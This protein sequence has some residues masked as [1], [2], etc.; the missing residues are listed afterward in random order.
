M[1]QQE[2]E[3]VRET[4]RVRRTNQRHSQNRKTA[5]PQAISDHSGENDYRHA[6]SIADIAFFDEMEE[7]G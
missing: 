2:E 6:E 7:L 1:R 5:K 3:A 4:K